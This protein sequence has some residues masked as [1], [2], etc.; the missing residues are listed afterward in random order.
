MT[1]RRAHG[2]RVVVVGPYSLFD[3]A[4]AALLAE[5]PGIELA[6]IAEG[7]AALPGSWPENSPDLVL[8]VCP[9]PADLER[10]SALGQQHPQTRVLCLALTWSL[11]Q[12]LATLHAGA[13]GCLS[14]GIATNELGMA[15]RQAARGEVTLSPDLARDL[16][17]HLAQDQPSPAGSHEKLTPREQE[18]LELV[19]HGLGNKEIAQRLFLSVR[20]V[21]NHLANVY[22]KLGVRS[23][24]EAAVLAVQQGWVD[25]ARMMPVG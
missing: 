9:R 19:C 5:L 25:A 16:I 17:T 20:T 13:I 24:T 22:R 2:I 18:V 10:L 11:D 8:A 4:L 14:A 21:E 12:A 3:E 15:L 7:L 23:R 1:E 6:G